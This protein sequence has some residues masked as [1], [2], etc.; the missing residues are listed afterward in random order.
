MRKRGY[1]T[2]SSK[3]TLTSQSNMVLNF[4]S[5]LAISVLKLT[6]QIHHFELSCKII[7]KFY[8]FLPYISEERRKHSLLWSS[9][10]MTFK[11]T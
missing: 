9:Y 6:N 11:T 1:K 10:H 2:Q 7:L 4:N 5:S 3:E 8:L